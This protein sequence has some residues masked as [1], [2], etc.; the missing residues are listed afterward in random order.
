MF[1]RNDT[2]PI[3]SFVAHYIET[4]PNSIHQG[5]GES[6]PCDQTAASAL[7]CHSP[8]HWTFPCLCSS[9]RAMSHRVM[10]HNVNLGHQEIMTHIWPQCLPDVEANF[11]NHVT[12]LCETTTW[13]H[14][15]LPARR[16]TLSQCIQ[17]EFM[18]FYK[19]CVQINQYKITGNVVIQVSDQACLYTDCTSTINRNGAAIYIKAKIRFSREDI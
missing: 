6:R 3:F 15:H 19:P 13:D 17:I 9:V 18:R 4:K 1:F 10:V 12:K 2:Q 11:S 14:Y 8:T 5:E 16:S 7:L